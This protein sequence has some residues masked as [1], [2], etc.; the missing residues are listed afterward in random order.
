MP[1]LQIDFKKNPRKALILM[2]LAAILIIVIYFSFILKPQVSGVAG[3]MIDVSKISRKL[4]SARKEILEI[5]GFKRDISAHKEKVD[6]YERMLPAEQEIPTLLENLSNMAKSSGVKIEGITPIAR[7]EEGKRPSE[8]Y[9][10]IPIL[11]TAES[12]YHELGQ[13]LS[14]LESAE[15]FMKV[16][17]I[18]MKSVKLTPKRH[19]VQLLVLTYILIRGR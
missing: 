7:K 8:V 1:N 17:D 6:S 13:L 15:R 14:K 5:P 18:E 16:A 4:N 19:S 9:Q 3:A 12:G 2:A 11:I 10:E